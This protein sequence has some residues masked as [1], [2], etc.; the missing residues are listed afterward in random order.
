[1]KELFCGSCFIL[2]RGVRLRLFIRLPTEE[3]P[4]YRSRALVIEDGRAR[5]QI[6]LIASH[7]NVLRAIDIIEDMHIHTSIHKHPKFDIVIPGGTEVRR[8]DVRQKL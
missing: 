4:L 8:A 5:R 3:G 2:A 7:T 1:M 6:I